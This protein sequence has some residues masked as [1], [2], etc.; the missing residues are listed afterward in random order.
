MDTKSNDK[1]KDVRPP[2]AE[3]GRISTRAV[4]RS[5]RSPSTAPRL[6][7]RDD[8]VRSLALGAKPKRLALGVLLEE[9]GLINKEMI[10][11]SDPERSGVAQSLKRS[12]IQQGLCPRRTF[13]SMP[14]TWR[15]AHH[16][17]DVDVTPDLLEQI[18]PAF[19][20]K[21]RVFPISYTNDELVIALN[22]PTNVGVDDLQMATGKRSCQGGAGNRIDRYIAK[23]YE[24]DEVAKIYDEFTRGTAIP[25]SAL[26][27][28]KR[29]LWNTETKT[30]CGPRRAS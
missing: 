3:S 12:L 15:R 17:R 24:G 22:D 5:P 19:A 9:A 16:V 6:T 29:F 25:L 8:A 27:N 13:S 23:Y 1:T 30:R 4:S 21:H 20:K 7:G 26:K 10:D 14:K 28:T 18:A 11:R 2:S